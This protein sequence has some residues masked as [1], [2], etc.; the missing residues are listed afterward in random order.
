MCLYF[1]EFLMLKIVIFFQKI[2]VFIELDYSSYLKNNCYKFRSDIFKGWLKA[3]SSNLRLKFQ[4]R[5]WPRQRMERS[6]E[7]I[8]QQAT[9]LSLQWC[10][11]KMML[12]LRWIRMFPWRSNL[13]YNTKSTLLGWGLLSFSPMEEQT[14]EWRRN[15]RS[16]QMN[17]KVKMY[18]NMDKL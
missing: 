14:F 4:L 13:S 1:K 12:K 18:Y 6:W 7:W 15:C 3:F 8:F 10:L 9:D 16:P 5:V 2:K 17:Q 11:I